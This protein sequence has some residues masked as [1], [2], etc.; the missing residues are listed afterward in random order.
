[1]SN[2]I[3]IGIAIAALVLTVGMVSNSLVTTNTFGQNFMQ[4]NQTGNQTGNQTANQTSPAP[5]QIPGSASQ[6]SSGS[7]EPPY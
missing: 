4:A 1:M 3:Q 5:A 2:R 6:G 7:S